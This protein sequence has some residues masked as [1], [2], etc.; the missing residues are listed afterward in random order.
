MLAGR[1]RYAHSTHSA[2]RLRSCTAVAQVRPWALR[3]LRGPA[4]WRMQP[5][6]EHSRSEGVCATLLREI[7]SGLTGESAGSQLVGSEIPSSIATQTRGSPTMRALWSM[8]A[9]RFGCCFAYV[10]TN[11]ASRS[12][13]APRGQDIDKGTSACGGK[14]RNCADTDSGRRMQYRT[15]C[16]GAVDGNAGMR[17]RVGAPTLWANPFPVHATVGASTSACWLLGRHEQ[18]V[19]GSQRIS[20]GVNWLVGPIEAG[21]K[22]WSRSAFGG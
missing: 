18:A 3:M 22:R 1:A 4:V 21:P 11:R 14:S 15:S 19:G 10:T 9:S 7:C 8:A 17:G 5:P 16:G 6:I 20:Q 12:R 13:S 2:E